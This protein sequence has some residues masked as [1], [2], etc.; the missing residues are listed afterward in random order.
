LNYYSFANNYAKVAS[1]LEWTLKNS[2]MRLLAAKFKLF[3]ITPVL[4]KYGSDLR[5]NDKNAFFKP[6][7]TTNV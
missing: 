4:K 7:Y 2:C 1:S 5:G 3:R 6:T